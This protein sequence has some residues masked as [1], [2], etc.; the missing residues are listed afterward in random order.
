VRRRRSTP[1]LA[2]RAR[3]QRHKTP[4]DYAANV[5]QRLDRV[6]SLLREIQQTIDINAKRLNALQAQLDHLSARSRSV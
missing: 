5:A 1:E 2:S 4:S 6:E 3:D